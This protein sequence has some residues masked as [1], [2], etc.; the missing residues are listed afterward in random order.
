MSVMQQQ[1]SSSIKEDRRQIIKNGF[2]WLTAAVVTSLCYPILR[3][4]GFS[5]PRKPRFVRIHKAMPASGF[6]VERDFVLF[7]SKVKTWAVSR[8]CTHLG[9]RLNFSE[10]QNQFICPCHESRFNPTGKRIAGPARRDLPVYL[11]SKE[12]ENQLPVYVVT[13]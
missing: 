12:T 2:S 3:F 1:R 5:R 4:L 6:L 8:K 9:C 11:V 10:Q 7:E 13:I